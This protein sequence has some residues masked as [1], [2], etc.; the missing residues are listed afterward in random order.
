MITVDRRNN[1]WVTDPGR[2]QVLKFSAS[3]ELLMEMGQFDSPGTKRI[4]MCQPTHVSGRG[5]RVAAAAK[6][7]TQICSGTT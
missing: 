1:V 4:H 7:S 5:L 2:Q 6:S 3:G